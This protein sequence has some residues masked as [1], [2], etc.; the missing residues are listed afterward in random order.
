MSMDPISPTCN[1]V[2]TTSQA[3]LVHVQTS[4]CTSTLTFSLIPQQTQMQLMLNKGQ[5]DGLVWIQ[6][7][8][9]LTSME[10][11]LTHK[12]VVNGIR[13]CIHSTPKNLAT[14]C[15]L[16]RIVKQMNKMDFRIGLAGTKSLDQIR[17]VFLAIHLTILNIR[18]STMMRAWIQLSLSRNFCDWNQKILR[19]RLISLTG[20]SATATI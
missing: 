4:S 8:D 10:L 14:S 17:T 13:L 6:C 1:S 12:W 3:G 9:T 15:I 5:I 7:Q 18:C 11:E 2:L 19:F 16:P 20:N